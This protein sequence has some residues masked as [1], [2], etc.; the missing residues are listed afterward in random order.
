MKNKKGAIILVALFAVLL[1]GA[2]ILYGNLSKNNNTDQLVE[3]GDTSKPKK[4]DGKPITVTEKPD[5]DSTSNIPSD[6]QAAITDT[7]NKNSTEADTPNPNAGLELAPNFTVYDKSGAAVNLSDFIGKPLVL[8]FWASWCGPCRSEMPDFNTAH[9]ELKDEVTFLMVNL[10]DGQRDTVNSAHEFITAN[11]YTFPVYYDT[12]GEAA[13][14]YSVYS[15]P[16]TFFINAD[17]Y[18]VAQANGAISASTLMQ[19]IELIK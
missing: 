16:T 7:E 10:T 6:S 19:G 11:G 4:D 18:L 9:L 14:I 3:L 13:H 17:G 5:S 1:I 2:Y 8:N 12:S 15:I